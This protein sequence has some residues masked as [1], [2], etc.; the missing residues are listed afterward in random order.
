[1][2]EICKTCKGPCLPFDVHCEDCA[3]LSLRVN[4]EDKY[5]VKDTLNLLSYNYKLEHRDGDQ[6]IHFIVT[7]PLSDHDALSQIV[8]ERTGK[9]TG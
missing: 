1:M 7:I 6:F 5:I 2:D 8:T 4:K 3:P 9:P